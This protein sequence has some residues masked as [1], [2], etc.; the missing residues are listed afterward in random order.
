MIISKIMDVVVDVLWLA[1]KVSA[2]S[3]RELRN[4]NSVLK[5]MVF[6]LEQYLTEASQVYSRTALTS[7]SE[8][9]LFLSKGHLCIKELEANIAMKEK[10]TPYKREFVHNQHG[11]EP[12]QDC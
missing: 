8:F 4:L 12:R 11:L 2:E 1:E 6:L 9:F 5:V 3:T 7:F 10:A